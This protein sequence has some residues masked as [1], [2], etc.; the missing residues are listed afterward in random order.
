[1]TAPSFGTGQQNFCIS[2]RDAVF[3]ERRPPTDPDGRTGFRSS[4]RDLTRRRKG[5]DALS[6][7]V[8]A[9]FSAAFPLPVPV[10][11]FIDWPTRAD[12]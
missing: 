7:L 2:L 10:V 11:L 3:C 9:M 5:V 8:T 1:M 12:R 4:R 6:E